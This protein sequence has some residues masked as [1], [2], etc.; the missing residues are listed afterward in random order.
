MT[1]YIHI[2]TIKSKFY[3]TCGL[4]SKTHPIILLE[5][6]DTLPYHIINIGL[7]YGWST[8]STVHDTKLVLHIKSYMMEAIYH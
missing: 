2:P 4:V 1:L 6:T 8:M 5:D 3:I 7:S